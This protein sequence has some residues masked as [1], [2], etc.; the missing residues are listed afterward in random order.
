ME[1]DCVKLYFKITPI[2]EILK[3]IVFGYK[4]KTKADKPE[5]VS[6][7]TVYCF[8]KVSEPIV[9]KDDI[10]YFSKNI[11]WASCVYFPIF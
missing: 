1:K 2:K 10:S 11:F 4:I 8:H 7:G 5:L 9:V 3:E 6:S